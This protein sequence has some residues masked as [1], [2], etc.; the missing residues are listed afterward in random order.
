MGG[1]PKLG[2]GYLI[3]VLIITITESYYLEVC[4]KGTGSFRKPQREGERERERGQTDRDRERERESE[5]ERLYGASPSPET[6]QSYP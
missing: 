4:M 6:K 2:G 3:G 1:R 5:R